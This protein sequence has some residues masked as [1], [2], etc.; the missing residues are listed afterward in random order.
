[1]WWAIGS[2]RDLGRSGAFRNAR[3]P[4]ADRRR[5]QGWAKGGQAAPGPVGPSN[6]SYKKPSVEEEDG[7][8]AG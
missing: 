1:M 8:Y 6:Q 2:E 4:P 5:G 3:V 7:D